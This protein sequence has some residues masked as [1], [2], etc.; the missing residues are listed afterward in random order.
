MAW[1]GA[2]GRRLC[3]A[4]MASGDLQMH[5]PG[6]APANGKCPQFGAK[7]E[8]ERWREVFVEEEFGGG[9]QRSIGC[10]GEGREQG[11]S[12]HQSMEHPRC[13]QVVLQKGSRHA[14]GLMWKWG[15]WPPR[16][17]A[18]SR[19]AIP[20]AAA[21]SARPGSGES[22]RAGRSPSSP[23]GWLQS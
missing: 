18:W 3:T 7:R 22:P 21:P 8:A 20:C 13:C 2:S 11:C 6:A 1:P 19:P 5:G 12:G 17:I 9:G 4:Q 15:H 10:A 14:L 16:Q 23:Y